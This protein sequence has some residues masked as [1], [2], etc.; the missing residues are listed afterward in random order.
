MLNLDHVDLL[1]AKY[2]KKPQIYSSKFQELV[3][4]QEEIS[5]PLCVED[6]YNLYLKIIDCIENCR[7]M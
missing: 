6:A 5:D 3:I 2:T 7:S 1:S 4:S